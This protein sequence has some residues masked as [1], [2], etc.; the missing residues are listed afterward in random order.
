MSK[1]IKDNPG[2]TLQSLREQTYKNFEC[3][4]MDGNSTDGTQNIVNEYLDVV[5]VFKFLKTM[6]VELQ[7]SIKL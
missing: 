4:V 5:S 3:I 6:K 1:C 7:L 2:K